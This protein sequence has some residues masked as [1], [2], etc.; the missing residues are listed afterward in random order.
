[1]KNHMIAVIFLI[2]FQLGGEGE[3]RFRNNLLDEL[4]GNEWK[5]LVLR[6][7]L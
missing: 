1:M 7:K 2:N 4:E 3:G 5:K 6:W